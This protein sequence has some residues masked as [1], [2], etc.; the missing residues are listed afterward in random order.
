MTLYHWCFK[1]Y[2]IKYLQTLALHLRACPTF[3]CVAFKTVASIICFPFVKQRL[4]TQITNMSAIDDVAVV[5]DRRDVGSAKRS[6]LVDAFLRSAK[7]KKIDLDMMI[8]VTFFTA[9]NSHSMSRYSSSHSDSQQFEK[10][11]FFVQII[12]MDKM[13]LIHKCLDVMFESAFAP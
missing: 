12:H 10:H 9:C 8:W 4:A 11:F 3:T 2:F 5:G 6:R 7:K 1:T 13:H